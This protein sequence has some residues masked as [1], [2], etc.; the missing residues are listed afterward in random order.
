MKFYCARK[1]ID[2]S[3]CLAVSLLGTS[4]ESYLTNENFGDEIRV[5]NPSNFYLIRQLKS[6]DKERET[7]ENE[8]Y[9]GIGKV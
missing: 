1:L 5:S 4:Y 3:F 9:L 8:T 6:G 7:T 2:L